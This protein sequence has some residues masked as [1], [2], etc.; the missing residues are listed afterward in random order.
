MAA[1]ARDSDLR[2]GSEFLKREM[3]AGFSVQIRNPKPINPKPARNPDLGT[4]NLDE[5]ATP[6]FYVRTA[7]VSIL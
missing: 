6:R 5:S 1:G 2:S 3:G 4:L 7:G